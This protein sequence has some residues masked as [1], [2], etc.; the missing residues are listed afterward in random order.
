[1]YNFFLYGV[2]KFSTRSCFTW[3]AMWDDGQIRD[4]TGS[5]LDECRVEGQLS[6]ICRKAKS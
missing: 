6:N 2:L 3:T 5:D 4:N 1:M